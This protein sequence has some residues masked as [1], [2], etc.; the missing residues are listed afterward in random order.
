MNA[1]L[2][3]LYRESA[4]RWQQSAQFWREMAEQAARANDIARMEFAHFRA[5]L[6]EA[7]AVEEL[8]KAEVF[9]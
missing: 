1:T 2:Q 3:I 7:Y 9:A 8:M 6:S 5:Q 4:A